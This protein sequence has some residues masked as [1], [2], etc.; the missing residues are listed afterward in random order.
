MA[1]LLVETAAP[2]VADARCAA[3]PLL[4]AGVEEV[5][6]FGSVA[7]GEAT[8][9]SDI[10]LLAL[11]ADIDYSKRHEL[12]RRLETA[13]AEAVGGRWPVQVFVTDRP[14]WKARCEQVRTSFEHQISCGDMIRV[15]VSE[16][17][18]AVWWTKP[19]EQPMSDLAEAWSKFDSQIVAELRRWRRHT[20]TD[21]DEFDSFYTTIQQEDVRLARMVD[22]CAGAAMVIEKTIKNLALWHN[23]PPPTVGALR[24]AGHNIAACLRLLPA[25]V[26]LEVESRHI[27]LRIDLQR[28]SSW[29]VDATYAAEDKPLQHKADQIADRYHVA[30]LE[31]VSIL[32]SD[33]A[34]ASD[35]QDEQFLVRHR[36]W[37]HLTEFLANQD[38]RSG[39]PA[40]RPYRERVSELTGRETLLDDGP[41]RSPRLDFPDPTDL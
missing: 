5:W 24:D 39:Q 26:R 11:F 8:V 29:R 33:L 41:Q 40:L 18:G 2:S 25:G 4:D 12:R 30:A 1:A 3:A 31:T 22:V 19:M 10:D 7:R 36:A 6:L 21:P 23:N 16:S 17:R 34:A 27:G 32:Y 13:A 37:Q 15:G 9:R 38:V 20:V 35:T 28:M 14:E